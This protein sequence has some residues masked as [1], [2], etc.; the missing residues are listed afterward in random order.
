M[1]PIEVRVD[2]REGSQRQLDFTFRSLT[3]LKLLRNQRKGE[4]YP[5]VTFEPTNPASRRRHLRRASPLS[6]CAST[7]P[8]SSCTKRD[9]DSSAST[10]CTACYPRVYVPHLQAFQKH[11]YCCDLLLRL[12]RITEADRYRA[13]LR[14]TGRSRRE[15]MPPSSQKG[16]ADVSRERQQAGTPWSVR[17]GAG[18]RL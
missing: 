6:Y 11:T 15:N 13:R 5:F 3:D 9:R 1:H 17:T 10:H 2:W 16:E 18:G 4:A 14:L 7:T 12:E 8:P